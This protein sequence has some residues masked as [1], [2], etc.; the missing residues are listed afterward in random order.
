MEG[1]VAAAAVTVEVGAHPC[2]GQ[3]PIAYPGGDAPAGRGAY[4][5]AEYARSSART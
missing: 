3:V 2:A 5:D 4:T 1:E